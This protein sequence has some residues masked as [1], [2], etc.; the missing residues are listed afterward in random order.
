MAS[1]FLTHNAPKVNVY[2]WSC[3]WVEEKVFTFCWL[4]RSF[5]VTSLV[6]TWLTAYPRLFLYGRGQ[7]RQAV[8]QGNSDCGDSV[9][10]TKRF[11]SLHGNLLWFWMGTPRHWHW[12]M[13]CSRR[14]SR[15]LTGLQSDRNQKW[16][17]SSCL[18]LDC[19]SDRYT[20]K[21]S[22]ELQLTPPFP[23]GGCKSTCSRL[24]YRRP[25]HRYTFYARGTYS[26]H[27]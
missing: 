3:L 25:P 24:C 15:K 10:K 27:I 17:Y 20:A 19:E 21:T 12:K 18:V 4:L 1:A 26:Y 5:C 8:R 23:E 2:S 14:N 6:D 13:W 11:K 7:N 16:R 9:E 22:I